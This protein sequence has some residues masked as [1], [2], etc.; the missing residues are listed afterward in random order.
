MSDWSNGLCG[1][2]NDV[3]LCLT[4]FCAPC[5]TFGK[6]A[7][8]VGDDCLMCGIATFVPLA[9]IWFATQ[10]RGKV[11]DQKGI[12]GSFVHDLA[13]VCCCSLCSLMQEAQEMG[14]KAPFG[15]S[16]ARS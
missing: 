1:C 9:N 2:F 5:Y 7:E 6:T 12:Q 11:R 10:I 16:I 3:P 15:N 8:T 14:V 13:M 4:T